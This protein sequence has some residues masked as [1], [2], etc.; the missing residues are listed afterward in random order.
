MAIIIIAGIGG[1]G[2]YLYRTKKT[3]NKV[4][5]AI[6]DDNGADSATVDS[7]TADSATTETDSDKGD[8]KHDDK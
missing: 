8:G 1:G 7:T 2:Y 3:L 4:N 5:S 6:V